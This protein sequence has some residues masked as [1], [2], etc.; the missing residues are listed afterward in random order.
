M[1]TIISRNIKVSNTADNPLYVDFTEAGE[2][3]NVYSEI[4]SLAGLASADLVLYTVPAGKQLKLK[5]VDYSG[6]NRAI[7]QITLNAN[8]IAK[9]RIYYLDFN[10]SFEFT[11]YV[12]E[13]GDIV[14]LLVEN[15]TNMTADFNGNLQGKLLDA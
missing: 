4:L 11:D 8:T 15:K 1:G 12:L 13:A 14:K 7:Y 3:I 2:S 5:R 10:G 9:Q 6:G